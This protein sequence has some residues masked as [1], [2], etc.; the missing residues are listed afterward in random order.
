MVTLAPSVFVPLVPVVSRLASFAVPPTAPVKVTPPVPAA[1]VRL[2][3]FAVASF[4]VP[5]KATVSEPVLAVTVVF[6]VSFTAEVP[7]PKVTALP[8][9]SAPFR[10]TPPVLAKENAL[11]SAPTA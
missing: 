7:E 1:T 8:T 2:W 6:P 9:V 10:F 5:P 11:P 4:T 3:V